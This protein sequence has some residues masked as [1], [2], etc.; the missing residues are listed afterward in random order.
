MGICVSM[1]RKLL[2]V[3]VVA[4]AG[5]FGQPAAYGQDLKVGFVNVPRVMDFAPQAKAARERIDGE[6][7]PRDRVLVLL[8]RELNE[9]ESLLAKNSAVMLSLIHI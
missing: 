2:V 5:I 7:A 4:T 8:Q 6:F 1:L 3:A 9:Q